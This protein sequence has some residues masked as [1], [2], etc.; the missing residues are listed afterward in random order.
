M[1]GK[2]ETLYK[3]IEVKLERMKSAVSHNVPKEDIEYDA[4]NK[5]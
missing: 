5:E 4:C 1:A 3:V 2:G